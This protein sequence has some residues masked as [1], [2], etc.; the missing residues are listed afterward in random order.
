MA[1]SCFGR[2]LA[3]AKITRIRFADACLSVLA[4]APSAPAVSATAQAET[5]LDR[6][7]RIIAGKQFVIR[8]T[9]FIPTRR[10]G[11]A[12]V[13]LKCARAS[14]SRGAIHHRKGRISRR[15]LRNGRTIRHPRGSARAFRRRRRHDGQIPLKQMILPLVV[16]RRDPAIL[17]KI[18]ITPSRSTICGRGRTSTDA[19]R[20]ASRGVA[21]RYVWIGTAIQRFKRSP[22]PAWSPETSSFSS[23]SAASPRSATKWHQHRH[24]REDEV[25]NL[26]P[27]HGTL[28]D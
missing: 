2:C 18:P 28:S 5:Q 7:Y 27:A 25:G 21:H 3:E 8:P 11:R 12:S 9:V 10:S 6:A 23:S 4:A 16:V 1:L 20:K 22:F 13:R 17:V 26:H 24:D 19:Y 15:I 14:R